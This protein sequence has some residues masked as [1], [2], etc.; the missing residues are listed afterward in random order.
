VGQKTC[1]KNTLK[2]QGKIAKNDFAAKE[3][4]ELLVSGRLGKRKSRGK[5]G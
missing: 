4:E 5:D 1:L 3:C 2:R